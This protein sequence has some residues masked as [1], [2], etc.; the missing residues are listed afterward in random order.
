MKGRQ[1]SK[2][3]KKENEGMQLS[4]PLSI[5]LTFKS[6]FFPTVRDFLCLGSS[7]RYQCSSLEP[8]R[9]RI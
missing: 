6:Y 1:F 5:L 3:E 7:S 9:K 2:T 4:H 8:Q